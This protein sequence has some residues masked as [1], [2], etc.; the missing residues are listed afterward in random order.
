MK[1]QSF[2]YY[3]VEKAIFFLEQNFR[4]QPDLDEIA[5]EVNLSPF[6]FQRLFLDW[7]GLTPKKFLQYLTIDHLRSRINQS[8]NVM[9]AAGLAGLSS[10]SRV[11]DLFIAIEGMSPQQY[12]SGG[13]GM[14]IFYGYHATPFGMCFIAMAER[15]ICDLHFIDEALQRNEFNAFKQ[16][17]HFAVLSHRPDIT[18]SYIQRIFKPV[19]QDKLQLLV[20]GSDF[21]I[22]VWE[23]LLKIPFGEVNS[24]QQVATQTGNSSGVRAVATAAGRNPISY[25]IPCHRIITQ[26]GD[27]GQFQ[28]GRIRK[29]A[30]I[31]W[32][33]ASSGKSGY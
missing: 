23:A 9:E 11:Y 3:R 16:K 12:K 17:W 2:N 6:H 7:V 21:Q 32:E 29:K 5:G 33:M 15:G 24:Y 13:G 27:V 20:Q 18:Q 8:N 1:D 30:M 10:Q 31:A 25:L 4:R 14:E 28:L 26:S 19:A 22:K